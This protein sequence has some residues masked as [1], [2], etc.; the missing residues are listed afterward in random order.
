MRFENLQAF[1]EVT[2]CKSMTLA[3]EHLFTTPQNIS[4]LIRE[5][6]S[7]LG[8]KLLV[9]QKGN[10]IL[11]VEG[12]MAFETIHGIMEQYEK[13]KNDLQRNKIKHEDMRHIKI[14]TS[15]AASESMGNFLNKILLNVPSFT[16]EI[17]E[18]DI[19]EIIKE[20]HFEENMVE[21]IFV[22]MQIDVFRQFQNEFD[23]FFEIYILDREKCFVYMNKESIL[24]KKQYISC[25]Q[26]EQLPLIGFPFPIKKTGS[27]YKFFIE[28]TGIQLNT[29]LLSNNIKNWEAY[30]RNGKAYAFTVP[31]IM[32]NVQESMKT[33]LI[34]VP[35]KEK[36]YLELIMF[37]RKMR[38]KNN[39][40]DI[41]YDLIKE[42]YKNMKTI[43][44]FSKSISE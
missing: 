26:L 38:K 13:L 36:I 16:A 4:K 42:Q 25:K 14:L 9:R 18:A 2:K 34:K 21:Y 6:E 8:N 5:L 41:L 30:L 23:K 12:E 3:S 24:A 22:W 28:S 31:S 19:E 40:S 10:M 29:I 11:T 1:L 17:V 27:T 15:Y 32:E 20:I 35:L 37:K 44:D 7:E 33:D 39:Q 43:E